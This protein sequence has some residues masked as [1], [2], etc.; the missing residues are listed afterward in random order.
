VVIPGL[1]SV[2]PSWDPSS[3]VPALFAPSYS[4]SSPLNSSLP[5]SLIP[6]LAPSL[7]HYGSGPTL[8]K[9]PHSPLPLSDLQRQSHSLLVHCYVRFGWSRPSMTPVGLFHAYAPRKRAPGSPSGTEIILLSTIR[10]IRSLVAVN[11]YPRK[12]PIIWKSQD[13]FPLFLCLEAPMLN[14]HSSEMRNGRFHKTDI[15]T[16][17]FYTLAT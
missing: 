4:P 8:G 3:P 10:K 5:S 6:S 11:C 2:P 14:N 16:S 12:V 1:D 17:V 15:R 7:C 9:V 13:G